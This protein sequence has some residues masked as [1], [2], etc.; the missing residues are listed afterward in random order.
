MI[1]SIY[2]QS[3]CKVLNP[4]FFFFFEIT[5]KEASCEASLTLST[6]EKCRYLVDFFSIRSI[7]IAESFLFETTR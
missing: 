7:F 4:D 2:V 5:N 3:V 1:R 6:D